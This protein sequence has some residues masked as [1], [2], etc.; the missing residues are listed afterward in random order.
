MREG[1]D[2]RTN[3]A[4]PEAVGSCTL[5]ATYLLR[6]C[7]GPLELLK[8]SSSQSGHREFSNGWYVFSSRPCCC[9]GGYKLKIYLSSS[10]CVP[11][12]VSSHICMQLE[13]SND[14]VVLQSQTPLFVR[15]VLVG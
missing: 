10:L 6:E 8:I 2:S 11:A 5:L 4:N 9:N 13:C 12:V 14:I 7:T 3:P 1:K 15:E